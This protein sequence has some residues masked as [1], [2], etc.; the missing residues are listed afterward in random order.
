MVM[1]RRLKM[2][3]WMMVLMFAALAA[4]VLR[5]GRFLDRGTQAASTGTSSLITIQG[6]GAGT[7]LGDYISAG[8][9][10]LNTSYHYFIEVPP[11]LGELKV[12]IFDADV[13]MGGS[14]EAD[15]GRD[16]AR[17][18]TFNSSAHYTLFNPSGASQTTQFTTGDASGPAGADN[19]WLTFFDTTTQPIANGHWELRVDMSSTVTT[20]DDINAFGIRANDGT[21]GAGG[22]E[23]NIY[24]DSFAAIGVNPPT[25][26]TAARSYSIYP[27]ITSGCSCSKN[28]FDYD[29]DSG[30]V[31]S[32]S[33][34]SRSGNFTQTFA[35]NSLSTNDTWR[36]DTVIG[37]TTDYNSVDYGIWTANATIKSYV[38]SGGQ[39][40]NLA[41]L[42]FSNYQAAANPPTA[43]PQQNTFRLYL[44]TD[45]GAAPVEPY[46]TQQLV[47]PAGTVPSVGQTLPV[48]V[49]LTVVNPTSQAI[50]FSNSNLVTT[51][52]PGAGA[53][54]ANHIAVSQGTVVSQPAVGGTGNITWNPGTVA[55]GAEAILTY[56]VN[57]TPT[58]AGEIIRVTGTPASGN[59]TRAQYVDETGNTTQSRATY[60]F[61]P[62]CELA[63]TQGL[64]LPITTQ[65]GFCQMGPSSFPAGTINTP[66]SQTISPGP[67]M[68]VGGSLPPGL[69]LNGN[70]L[71][72]TPTTAG[73]YSFTLEGA[74]PGLICAASK[75]YTMTIIGPLHHFAISAISSP[76]T[77]GTGFNVT[78][79]AQDSNNNTVTSFIGSVNLSTTAGTISPTT[80]GAFTSGVVTKSM[81]VTQP[82]TGKTITADDG[83]GHTG[84]SNTFTVNVGALHHF[85]IANIATQTANAPFNIS[86]T[87]QDVDNNTV[88]AFTGTVDLSMNSGTVSPT[89]SSPFSSGTLTQSVTVAPAGSLRTITASRTS[90]AE[91][92]MSNS[93]T[94]G[95]TY[96]WTGNTSNDWNT[97]TNWI[98]NAV[99]SS[100]NDVTI[101]ASGVSNDP[102][103]QTTTQTVNNLTLG[104]GRT[105]AVSQN[106]QVNGTLTMNGNNIVVG[107]PNTLIIGSAG[108][109][110]RTSGQILGSV[111]KTISGTGS[112][113]F[114]VGTANGY[115]PVVMNVTAGSGSLTVAAVQGVEPALVGQSSSSLQRYWNLSGSG[116]TADLT[117]N[118]L[119]GDVMGNEASYKILR[120]VG[121]TVVAWPNSSPDTVNHK[122]TASGVSSF[123]DWTLA[124]PTGPTAA[125]ATISG[126]IATADGKPLGGVTIH[127]SGGKARRTITDG[128]GNYHIDNVDTANFYTLTPSLANYHFAPSS[129]S[130]SLVGD[131]TD[132][133]FAANAD[134]VQT[135]NPI[136][137]PEFF[138]RQQYLDFLGRE[139]EENGF[140]GWSDTINNCA[141]GDANCDRV[142]VSESFFRSQEFQ[143]RGYFV[144]RFYSTAFGRKPDYAE[145]VPDFA[146]VRGFLTDDQLEAAKV[147]FVNDFMMRPVFANQYGTLGN[148][149][150]VD[151]LSQTAGVTLSSRQTLIDGLEHGTLTRA[152]VLRQIAE[153]S[154]VNQKYY[155]QAF[156]VMEYF[157]YLRRDPD[158][159]YLNWIDVLN[160]SGDSRQMVECF[161]DATEYRNRFKQ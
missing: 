133:V 127:L 18:G 87:A 101:P 56:Y 53:V 93:F 61:G 140:N 35:S 39:N 112:F 62:L 27:Y 126:Q 107:S 52:V 161:V 123:S 119:A 124:V 78:I 142:H 121:S 88:I 28:D 125:P 100:A 83:S 36:R 139:P 104:S 129:L 54:Y 103:I 90:G 41:D 108:S 72:G 113:T 9:G 3:R 1:N 146:R 7:S 109:V 29:S 128:N 6:S 30:D 8:T 73:N 14:A 42:Y 92:G 98:P 158:I 55:A 5:G 111:Q 132:A 131:K 59:G 151:A 71:S 149:Q 23:L 102:L 153:S 141:A 47:G 26:G 74:N 143:Q 134:A 99:P 156:V 2:G 50:T 116:I 19:T 96:T 25:S 110:S 31:G 70:N 46:V 75:A 32:I 130:F 60:L 154:E 148:A 33:M 48:I 138:V 16:R 135:A 43:N 155:N 20:G 145:F 21:A 15:A 69:S 160:Q 17:N 137:T 34:N 58:S 49:W 157:G 38:N 136:D 147:A 81:T 91:T 13:G 106:F 85:A 66:Y 57:V 77:A 86:L 159:L 144:Y 84:T 152:Q 67:P 45:A 40:G 79:T 63:V 4:M 94:L 51:N 95:N 150:Y 80:S 89:T 22:T 37:W 65:P 117:F 11:G 97:A 82:G 122:A 68:L 114:P 120:I 64:L 24:A 118:Y 44:P 115:S 76:Q 105:L 10:G 12:E